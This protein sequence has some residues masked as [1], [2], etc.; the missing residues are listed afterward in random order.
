MVKSELTIAR[1]TYSEILSMP[2]TR[3][4]RWYKRISPEEKEEAMKIVDTAGRAKMSAAGKGRVVSEETKAKIR[5]TLT[6]RPRSEDLKAKISATMMGENNHNFG[7]ARSKETRDKIGEAQMG[8][9]NH[10]WEGG[11]SFLPYCHL[12]N[13]EKKEEVR[14]HWGRVCI[15]SDTLRSTMGSESDLDDFEGHEVFNGRR[16]SVHHIRGNKM[17]GCD[18]TE[19][20]LIPLQGAF[21]SKKFDGFTLEDHPFYVTLFLLKNQE[22]RHHKGGK[23][24]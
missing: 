4:C 9:K 7:K 2:R 10:G 5:M 23:H 16:L 6:G 13:E 1:K 18:G 11:I 15:L 8:E 12:F 24:N 21:N 17:G 3:R 14:N 19:L 22:R 20:A